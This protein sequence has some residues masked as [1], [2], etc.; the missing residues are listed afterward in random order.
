MNTFQLISLEEKDK[1]TILTLRREDTNLLNIQMMTEI[2]AALYSLVDGRGSKALVIKADGPVF[3]GGLDY[4][5]VGSDAIDQLI[6]PYHK[7]FRLLDRIECPTIALVQGAALGAGCELA[8]FCDMV[9]ASDSARFGL[10]DIKLGLFSPVAAADFPR[11]GHLKH[12]FELLLIGDSVIAEEARSMG[13][14]NHVFPAGEFN[15]KCDEF[16]Y[17]LISNPCAIL[18]LAKRALRLGLDKK[19]PDA[20]IESE[21]VYLRDMAATQEAKEG[22]KKYGERLAGQS[23]ESAS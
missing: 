7:M 1:V 22:L 20:L 10:P 2:N 14:I 23:E 11:Y 19:F 4:A 12:I 8:C 16:L 9:L 6:H 3:C 17:R 21:G 18:R 15:V 13:L 5:E